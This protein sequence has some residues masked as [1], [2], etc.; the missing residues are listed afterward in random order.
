MQDYSWKNSSVGVWER[1]I[2][3]T[4]DYFHTA[5]QLAEPA[6]YQVWATTVVVT[7][8]MQDSSSFEDLLRGAWTSLRHEYPAIASVIK[9]GK[10]VY[11]SVISSNVLEHWLSETV[12]VITQ[13]ATAHEYFPSLN[14]QILK[15]PT[16]Y[17]FP[18]SKE[19]AI[20]CTHDWTDGEGVIR[21][22]D[23]L[24][25]KVYH[26][27]EFVFAA[28]DGTEAVRLQASEPLQ[29]AAN[30]PAC[31][32]EK[33]IAQAGE[34]LQAFASKLPSLGFPAKNLDHP[35]GT[36]LRYEI[37]FK[38]DETAEIIS[39][40]RQ[41]GFTPTHIIHAACIVASY[42]LSH[43]TEKEREFAS[44]GGIFGL[45]RYCN[46]SAK[47]NPM[48]LNLVILPMVISPPY[49]DLLDVAG[50]VKEYYTSSQTEEIK[51]LVRPIWQLMKPA[52]LPGAPP[53]KPA[54]DPMISSLGNVDPLLRRVHGAE[55]DM[56]GQIRDFWIAT[57][58][59]GANLATHLWT[60]NGSMRMGI[61]YNNRYYGQDE[62]KIFAE[63]VREIVLGG[64]GL[65]S[66]A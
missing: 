58:V 11:H 12:Q 13:P 38:P 41:Q 64:L 63:L 57:T 26:R 28:Y 10:K 2:D 9:N 18:N 7:I 44:Y 54:T 53:P 16:L 3:D 61:S 19:V 34:Y 36:S 30:L 49:T 31:I 46:Q 1:A 21:L 43:E 45:R 22:L 42:Q 8:D 60:W 33:D 37:G 55:G 39:A 50:R 5:T 25:E 17:I 14:R 35:P 15:Q 52:I 59:L 40:G 20:R 65:T 48:G 29:T 56:A 66:M 47:T 62:V 32:S 6:G 27:N 24:V 4:E 51:N 23:S